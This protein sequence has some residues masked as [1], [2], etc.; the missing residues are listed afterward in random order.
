MDTDKKILDRIGERLKETVDNAKE[1]II[2]ESPSPFFPGVS[3]QEYQKAQEL[4]Q[5]LL[6]KYE[7]KSFEDVINGEE[8]KTKK[9]MCYKI[10]TENTLTITMMNKEKARKRILSD[11]K[12]VYGIGS[13][14]EQ[15]LKAEGYKTIKDLLD[16][17]RFGAEAAKVLTIDMGDLDSVST[18][19][20]RWFSKSHPLLL[21]SASFHDKTNFIIVDIETMGLFSRPII[22]CG[23]AQIGETQLSIKQYLLRDIAEEP[24]ALSALLSHTSGKIFVTFNGKSFDIP[25]IKERLAYYGIQG[26][27]E[28]PH[29]DL[30]HFSRRAWRNNVPDCRLTTLEKYLFGITRED[31]VPSGLVP[32]FYNTYVETGNIGSLVPIIEHNKQDIVTS[33]NIF[34][35]LHQEWE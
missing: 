18:W 6:K 32:D 31:D 21:Y 12:L 13:I 22:L 27:L 25:Y 26:E 10:D 20:G 16:H 3:M 30:L 11:L 4:K 24:G 33:A 1:D 35:R 29:F 34:S 28:N 7:G 5:Q 2:E 15:H 23:I 14:T 19:I 17:P 9:G 8:V